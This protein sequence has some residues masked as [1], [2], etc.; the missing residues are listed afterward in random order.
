MTE[1]YSKEY[2]VTW[3]M[4]DI[5]GHLGNDNYLQLAA[6]LRISFMASC[7]FGY[8][9]MLESGFAFVILREFTEYKRELFLGD[10]FIVNFRLAALSPDSDRWVFRHEFYRK[11]PRKLCGVVLSEMII[12]DTK[13]RKMSAHKANIA[14]LA[15]KLV[16]T[17]EFRVLDRHHSFGLQLEK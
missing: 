11:E 6:G 13:T 8:R 17:K 10:L 4:V 16:K 12:M 3:S 2:E 15:D 9:T 5:N 7:G 14:A 1:E